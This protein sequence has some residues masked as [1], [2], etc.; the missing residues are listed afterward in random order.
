MHNNRI[1]LLISFLLLI[2]AG[3]SAQLFRVELKNRTD[4]YF[5]DAKK[6][7]LL[8]F[9][10]SIHYTQIN[11]TT[12]ETKVLPYYRDPYDIF[13]EFSRG[14][15]II[16]DKQNHVYFVDVGCGLVYK[17]QN[18]SIIRIDHSFHHKNQFFGNIFL[19]D[20]HPYIFG[21]YGYFL[22]KNMTTSFNFTSKE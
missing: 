4:L 9:D 7:S 22:H 5:I 14:Y 10:D 21:G 2:V 15:K 3:V 11:L 1:F 8:I 6:N 17:W 16:T 20:G 13:S 19:H 18:D 12:G